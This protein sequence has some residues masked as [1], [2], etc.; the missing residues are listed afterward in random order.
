MLFII[1]INDIET[2]ILST[3]S[4]FA[5]DCKIKREVSCDE[6]AEEVQT[7]LDTLATWSDKWQ[8]AFHPDKCKVLH[9]GHNNSKRQYFINGIEITKVEEEK[10]LGIII[11]ED[12]K[13]KK[14]IAKIVKRANRLLGMIRRTITSKTKTNIMNLYK[15]LIRPIL[16]YGAAVWSPHQKGDIQ[17]LEKVQR[18]ATKLI[19]TIRNLPYEERLKRCKLMSLE[20]RRRRYDLIETFKIMKR[21]YKVDPTKLFKTKESQTRGHSLKIYKPHSRLNTRKNFFSQ[22]VI[23]D[24]NKLPETAVNA[25]N[26]LNFKTIIDKEFREGGLYMIQ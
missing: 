7:D 25:K 6:H 17:K 14:H 12:L 13:P 23:N 20:S 22:R 11:S 1:F 26:I 24:W 18:R 5:D 21:I 8:M 2:G 19:K 15:T 16:D 9:L 4:K 3:L 10:D